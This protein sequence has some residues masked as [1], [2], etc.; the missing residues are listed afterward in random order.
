MTIVC[1]SF[2]QNTKISIFFHARTPNL[3]TPVR[4]AHHHSPGRQQGDPLQLFMGAV[5][6]LKQLQEISCIWLPASETMLWFGHGSAGGKQF[7][8]Y[9]DQMKLFLDWGELFFGYFDFFWLFFVM[10]LESDIAACYGCCF[11]LILNKIRMPTQPLACTGPICFTCIYFKLIYLLVSNN[12]AAIT[13]LLRLA[14]RLY[15]VRISYTS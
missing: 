10:F 14:Y 9:H 5:P 15:M 3:L 11:D 12:I 1:C 8:G 2:S 13:L 7:I 4:L 6:A